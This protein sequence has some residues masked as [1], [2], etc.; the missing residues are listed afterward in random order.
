MVRQATAGEAKAGVGAS[1]RVGAQ[2][3]TRGESGVRKDN[4]GDA[5]CAKC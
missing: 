3:E 5:E 2:E 4:A 1:C